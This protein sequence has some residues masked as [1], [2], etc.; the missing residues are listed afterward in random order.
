[1]LGLVF[2]STRA[3]WPKLGTTL[4]KLCARLAFPCPRAENSSAKQ[5]GQV[6]WRKRVRFIWGASCDCEALSSSFDDCGALHAVGEVC[7]HAF[8][9]PLNTI[10]LSTFS[11]GPGTQTS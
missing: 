2:L 5:S 6:R 3:L 11:H 4:R 1:M 9:D 10:S 7:G 8:G